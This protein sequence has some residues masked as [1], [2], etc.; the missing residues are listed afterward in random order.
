MEDNFSWLHDIKDNNQQL[1][2]ILGLNVLEDEASTMKAAE[3]LADLAQKLKFRLIFKA[4]F[5]KANRTSLKSFRGVGFDEGLKILDKVRST[6]K[7]PVDTDVHETHQVEAL[8]QVVDIIQIPAF[9]CR[10]TDLLIAAGKTGKVV[11]VKKGQFL[12][13]EATE[14]IIEKVTSTGNQSVWVGERGFAFGYN[15]LVVDYRTFPIMKRFGKPIIFDATHAV[16]RPQGLG[17]ATG[18]DRQFKPMLSAAAVVQGIAGMFIEMHE[19]P[20]KALCD[21]ANVIRPAQVAD[22]VSY[23]IDLDAW[24]KHHPMPQIIEQESFQGSRSRASG[25]VRKKALVERQTL[26][27]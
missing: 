18:G 2:F 17:P 23:L 20:E 25:R 1:F 24:V 5:D 13:P 9:L 12:N 21:A 16:Q 27:V 8:A 14:S 26:I 7:V 22:L 6:Y 3:F 15:N 4:S 19:N 11:F 10:Q